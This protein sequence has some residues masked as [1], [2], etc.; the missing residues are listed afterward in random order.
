MAWL[1]KHLTPFQVTE[2]CAVETHDDAIA[3]GYHAAI[4]GNYEIANVEEGVSLISERVL[5][6]IRVNKP[7]ALTP[8]YKV[9]QF[10]KYFRDIRFIWSGSLVVLTRPSDP[11]PCYD[12]GSYSSPRKQKDTQHVSPATLPCQPPPPAEPAPVEPIE[13]VETFT[14]R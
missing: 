14:D 1:K 12:I 7:G 9:K 8:F 13:P 2:V 5:L 4:W 6:A 10:Q 11:F 3:A